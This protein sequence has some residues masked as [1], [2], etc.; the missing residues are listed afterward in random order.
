MA[1][2]VAAAKAPDR[3]W[4]AGLVNALLR[5]FEREGA[6]LQAQIADLPQARWLFPGWLLRRIQAAWPEHWQAICDASNAHPP[7]TLRVNRLRTDRRAYAEQLVQAGIA[8][9]PLP[10]A[11]MAL[12][13]GTYFGTGPE[14]WM[15]LQQSYELEE[16]QRAA[17][18]HDHIVADLPIAPLEMN[19][20]PF[21]MAARPEAHTAVFDPG[22]VQGRGRVRVAAVGQV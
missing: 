19:H 20:W 3:P 21:Q 11:D 18:A 4:A 12:R 9:R 10:H 2:T 13:L 1:A 15:N 5:R 16:A 14:F 7:M 6:D 22:L 8:S 17:G